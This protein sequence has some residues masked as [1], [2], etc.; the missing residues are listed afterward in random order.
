V[1]TDE[2]SQVPG[3]LP[4]TCT[5]PIA[6]VPERAGEFQRL[7][8]DTVRSVERPESGRLRLELEPSQE[9]ARR[10]AELAV[11]ES[12]CCGFFTFTLSATSRRLTLDISV[13]PA[14]LAVLDGLARLAGA[15]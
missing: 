8:A 4:D 7:F 2:T 11:A 6:S 9:A 13:P 3:W 5:L 10:V 1:G 14:Q 15:R 12:A